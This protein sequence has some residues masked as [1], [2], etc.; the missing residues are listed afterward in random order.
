ME[1]MLGE[2]LCQF[3]SLEQ[4]ARQLMVYTY[5]ADAPSH[6]ALLTRR[7]GLVSLALDACR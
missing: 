4:A 5:V 6:C 2:G 1:S 3:S 7:R